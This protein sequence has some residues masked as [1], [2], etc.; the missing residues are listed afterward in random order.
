MRQRRC[1]L[2]A[3]DDGW[4]LDRLTGLQHVIRPDAVRQALQASGRQNRWTCCL[5]HEVTCWVVLA[6]GLLTDLP[7]RQVFKHARRLRPGEATPAP[8]SNWL[9]P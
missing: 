8:M 4:I 2:P 3:E 1:T 9:S 7:I 6:M 5:T